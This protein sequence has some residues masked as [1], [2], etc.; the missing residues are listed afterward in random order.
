MLTKICTKCGEELEATEKNFYRHKA[1]KYGF[2]SKCKKC[3]EICKKEYKEKNK[4]R[5]KKNKKES[6]ARYYQK[7]KEK[8]L[9]QNHEY[10]E[11]NKAEILKQQKKYYKENQERI[12]RYR[13]NNKERISK[14]WKQYYKENINERKIY[15]KVYR[16]DNPDKNR[17][18]HQRRHS[19]K[20]DLPHTL[21]TKQWNNIKTK[22]KN[23][24]CYC[25]DEK[26]LQQEHF[27]P[28]SRGGE[29]TTNNIIPACQNCNSSKNNSNFFEWYPKQE[30]YSK[31][32][33]QFILKYLGYKEDKQQL[34]LI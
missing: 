17:M 27:I 34:K 4:D 10:Y 13:R 3:Q 1:G 6:D 19:V 24:C 30:Y 26:P 7:H 2:N 31:E 33:E 12:K 29:Y 23:K 18:Y 5:Y 8:H 20:K 22:F 11:K 21:T 16:K 25:G 9:K 14:A 32:R 15:M 28:L